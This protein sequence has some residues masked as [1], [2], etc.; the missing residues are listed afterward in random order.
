MRS[1][2][3]LIGLQRDLMDPGGRAPCDSRQVEALIPHV[4]DLLEFLPVAKV[5]VAFVK[6]EI[7]G[8]NVFGRMALKGLGLKGQTGSEI[9]PR[10]R[11][12]RE[13]VF[14]KGLP[15]ALTSR[16]LRTWVQDRGINILVLAGT[17]VETCVFA[18]AKSAL[19]KG[20]GVKILTDCVAGRSSASRD[21][22]LSRLEAMGAHLVLHS[23][24]FKSVYHPPVEAVVQT[25]APADA[26]ASTE[27]RAV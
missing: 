21:A 18:T 2:L 9:D 6:N 11:Q 24:W 25:E 13:P 5:P 1:A 17:P 10:I 3:L 8:A 14:A 12:G 19:A 4:N 23:D 15:D 22:V 27:S 16:E 26:E 7:S 20:Y